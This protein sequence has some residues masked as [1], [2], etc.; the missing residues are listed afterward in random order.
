MY[1]LHFGLK[2]YVDMCYTT[3]YRAKAMQVLPP[4]ISMPLC[5]VFQHA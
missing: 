4:C 1:I 5:G 3:I 2:T